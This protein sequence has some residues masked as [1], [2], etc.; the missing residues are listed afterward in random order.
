MPKNLRP[1]LELSLRVV[2]QAVRLA[3]TGAKRGVSALVKAIGDRRR[4]S[5]RTETDP[6]LWQPSVPAQE[7]VA[8]PASGPESPV[9]SATP[10]AGPA[11]P[12]AESLQA[13]ASPPHVSAEPTL[14]TESADVGAEEGAGPELHVAEPWKGYA[15]M[16]ASEVASRLAEAT[17]EDV[18]VVQLYETAHQSRKTVL[19]A[20][21][22]R[23]KR[24][25]PGPAA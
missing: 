7:P 22:R 10:S 1:I 25:E 18:A 2:G 19:A 12:P 8:S 13:P 17:P 15:D 6:G 23:L 20:A 24:V 4:E 11:P 14:V 5:R 3:A 9:V 16:K 21:E